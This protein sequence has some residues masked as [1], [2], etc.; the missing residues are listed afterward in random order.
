[1]GIAGTAKDGCQS[2]VLAGGYED[3]VD[4]GDSFTYTGSGGR[5]LSGNKRTAEQSSDQEL[6]RM[7]KALALNVN[8][9]FSEEGAEATDWQGGKPVRVIRNAKGRKHSKYAPEEGNRYDG[10]YKIVKYWPEKGKSGFIVWRY[11]LRRDDPI[12][13]PWTKKGMKR[14]EEE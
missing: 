9:K 13:A 12:P 8:A 11:L 2:I 14:I 7:N 5:D 4:D 3:D 10:I 1:M 6:T